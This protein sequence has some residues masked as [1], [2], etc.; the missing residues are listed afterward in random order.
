MSKYCESDILFGLSQDDVLKICLSSTFPGTK[1]WPANHPI[2]KCCV[3]G[4]KIPYNAWSDENSLKD[5][6]SNMFWILHVSLEKPIASYEKPNLK[7]P[8]HYQNLK[9]GDFCL[10]HE[11][12]FSEAK[13]G[14]PTSLLHK[15][16]LRFTIAKI[17]PKVTALQESLFE[18]IIDEA[19]VDLRNG[20]YC[21][22]AGFG[23]IVRG[24]KNWL[25]HH[26]PGFLEKQNHDFIYAAD[27]NEDFCNFYGWRQKDVL[28]EYVETNS[29]VI[30]CPPFGNLTERFGNLDD[31]FYFDF[32][33]W[34][35]L[36]K[37]HIKAPA[38]V[39]IGPELDKDKVSND[40]IRFKSGVKP[41]GLFRHK[42]QAVYRPDVSYAGFTDE[43]QKRL[44]ELY[45]LNP[46][47]KTDYN[48]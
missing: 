18:K 17:A 1:K 43:D 10:A 14:D 22:M 15:V 26:Y 44:D 11:I 47:L 27:V 13:N 39:F 45:K 19:G 25:D 3:A 20:V 16:L 33:D 7:L 48:F 9:Y 6:I 46:W 34:C 5:A 42:V 40:K 38:Y 32:E 23:G 37:E 8:T 35:L 12:A 21:P 24:A 2:W 41:N 36:L 30:A 29:I 28:S 31:K 4:K